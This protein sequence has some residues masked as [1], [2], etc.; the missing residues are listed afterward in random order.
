[1]RDIN[2]R[3]DRLEV[4]LKSAH[5]GIL[6]VKMADG[7][8]RRLLVPDIIPLLLLDGDKKVVDVIGDGG[9]GN[10][11]LVDLLRGIIHEPLPEANL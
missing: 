7:S 3:L 9:A 4:A 5:E 10:G 8:E 2:K 11:Y 6:T 1:M